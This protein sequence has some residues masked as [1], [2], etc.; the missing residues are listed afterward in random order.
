MHYTHFEIE[1]FK[2]I[3]HLRLDLTSEGNGRIHTLVGLNESGKTTILEAIDFFSGGVEELD[4]RELAG[5]IRPNENDLVPIA[6]RANFN[7]TTRISAGVALDEADVVALQRHLWSQGRVELKD[8]PRTFTVRDVYHFS[9]SVYVRK[10]DL[11]PALGMARS[12]SGKK[13]YE[14][15]PPRYKDEWSTAAHFLRERMPAFGTFPTSCS[16]S[17]AAST[18]ASNPRNPQRARSTVPCSRTSLIL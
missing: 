7:D 6:K 8:V 12:Q 11:W 4:A 10:N 3:R 17:R 16:T 13:Y 14:F 5:R 1:N 9:N 2:G 18:C 15:F